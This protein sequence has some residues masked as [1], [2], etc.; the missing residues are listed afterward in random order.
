MIENILAWG[1]QNYT[2]NSSVKDLSGYFDRADVEKW[3][4][5]L[6]R[7]YLDGNRQVDGDTRHGYELEVNDHEA[8]GL[9]NGYGP[10]FVVYYRRRPQ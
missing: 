9:T 1:R 3:R 5:E 6:R 8:I 7:Q 2:G 4:K 10:G